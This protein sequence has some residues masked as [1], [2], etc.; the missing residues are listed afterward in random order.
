MQRVSW[1]IYS[2]PKHYLQHFNFPDTAL[3]TALPAHYD[4]G[5]PNRL[6]ILMCTMAGEPD[7]TPAPAVY[8][9]DGEDIAW[10]RSFGKYGQQSSINHMAAWL[11]LAKKSHV[12][13]R[14]PPSLSAGH[15]GCM[16]SQYQGW[17][18]IYHPCQC[19]GRP[20]IS[21]AFRAV[22]FSNYYPPW[23]V[24]RDFC[25]IFKMPLSSLHQ[26]YI[27]YHWAKIAFLILISFVLFANLTHTELTI[28]RQNIQ[29]MQELSKIV[30][31]SLRPMPNIY[32]DQ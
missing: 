29:T 31:K 3:Y 14:Y 23:C 27:C 1:S 17:E 32:F 19:S 7:L 22:D 11:F 24:R 18:Y 5:A 21:H 16:V 8:G 10:T 26:P 20:A 9:C 28:S 13:L 15:L 30:P 6:L 4:D 25:L 2:R 12:A